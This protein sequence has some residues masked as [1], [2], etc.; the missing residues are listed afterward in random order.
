MLSS[1]IPAIMKQMLSKKYSFFVLVFFVCSLCV[2]AQKIPKAKKLKSES[3]YTINLYE[4]YK[5]TKSYSLSTIAES[6]E[7]IPLETTS[8]CLLGDYL[9]NIFIDKNEII[10]FD[11]EYAYRFSRE[12]KFLNKV[13]KK[14]RGPGEYNRPM[15]IAIE[16][17][18]ACIYFLDSN[19]LLQYQYNGEFIK[20]FDLDIKAMKILKYQ[21][22]IFLVDDMFY[23]Y[24]K[25]EKRF[26][27]RFFSEED[28]MQIAKIEC[29]KKDKIPFAI[30]MPVMY[31]FNGNTFV[32]DYWDNTVFEVNDPLNLTEYAFINTGKLKAREK[33]D[34][35][36]FT[37]KE[38]QGEELVIVINNMAE[39]ER[40]IFMTSNKG[41]FF[42]D[43]S[44]SETYCCQYSQTGEKWSNFKNDIAS[45]PDLISS[46]PKNSIEKNTFATFN[47]AYEFFEDGVDSSNPAIKKLKQNLQ[48]DDNPVLVLIKLKE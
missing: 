38:N 16:P 24:A 40:Y 28:G 27:I 6:V 21:K 32:K 17:S 42:Y 13:G 4:A 9:N 12:G 47:N 29:P 7:F 30:D 20:E 37:G 5:N 25:P 34:R 19:R 1:K 26:S 23:Q 41:L 3:K 43:K 15:G 33:D 18:T 8:E 45:G 14:G 11:F 2:Q 44:L 39:S 48:P 10:V 22:G 36:V 31:S 46:F 35:S